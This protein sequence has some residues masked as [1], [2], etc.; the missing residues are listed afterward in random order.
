MNCFLYGN[1]CYFLAELTKDKVIVK[2]VERQER[3]S[4]TVDLVDEFV[5]ESNQK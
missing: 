2:A 4:L 1:S 3:V 5:K